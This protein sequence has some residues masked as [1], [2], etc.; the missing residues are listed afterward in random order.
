MDED[1]KVHKSQAG[2]LDKAEVKSKQ[3]AA[4]DTRQ[5]DHEEDMFAKRRA[6]KTGI[7]SPP[8]K[9]QATAPPEQAHAQSDSGIWVNRAPVL[10]LWVSTVAQQQGFSKDAGEYRAPFLCQLSGLY[11]LHSLKQHTAWRAT[12]IHPLLSSS[13]NF[14]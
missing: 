6:K 7:S 10:T 13:L 2:H 1:V 3:K 11:L 4:A 14:N 9:K 8:Q 12:Q 5:D